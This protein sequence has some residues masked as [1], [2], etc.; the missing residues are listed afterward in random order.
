MDWLGPAESLISSSW[1]YVVLFAISVLAAFLPA[2][3]SE[4]VI[5]LAGGYA[6]KGQTSLLFVILAAHG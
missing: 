3:P 5:V 4:P 1:L 6:A 2:V